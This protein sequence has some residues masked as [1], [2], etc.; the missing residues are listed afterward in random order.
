MTFAETMGLIADRFARRVTVSVS[1]RSERG[2]TTAMSAE[3]TL[4]P[5]W[6]Q[7]QLALG[8]ESGLENVLAFGFEEYDDVTF[9]VDREEFRDASVHGDRL[10]I[11]VGE[12]VE[13]T[14]EPPI[15]R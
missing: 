8:S 12:D 11:H 7:E 9:Y 4:K 6:T 5:G 1:G 14:I 15:P 13:I 2:P 3:G 10:S